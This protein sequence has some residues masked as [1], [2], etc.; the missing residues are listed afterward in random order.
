MRSDFD[1]SSWAEIEKHVMG[2][3]VDKL[4]QSQ[5]LDLILDIRDGAYK[6]GQLDQGIVPY[7]LPV[8]PPVDWGRIAEDRRNWM[9]EIA[10]K[11]KRG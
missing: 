5:L 8:P 11:A 9:K 7:D 2:W 3:G 1:I 10:E 4:S 6:V